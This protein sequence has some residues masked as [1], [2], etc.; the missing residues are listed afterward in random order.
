VVLRLIGFDFSLVASETLGLEL[1][2][3]TGGLE[4]ALAIYGLGLDMISESV[5]LNLYLYSD[6]VKED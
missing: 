5:G 4:L 2:R 1:G 6:L 3:E